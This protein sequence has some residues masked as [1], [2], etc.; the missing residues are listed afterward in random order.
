ME[1]AQDIEIWDYA[2]EQGF[3]I[4]TKDRDFLERS[5]LLGHPP[6]VIHIR[7]GKCPVGAIADLLASKSSQIQLFQKQLSRS[8][9]LLP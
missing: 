5:S 2:K 6:K 7:L 3:I 9:L 4:V 8:Y 1:Q